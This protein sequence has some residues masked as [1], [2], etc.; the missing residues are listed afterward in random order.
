MVPDRL[1][2]QPS[3]NATLFLSSSGKAVQV[4][5]QLCRIRGKE[6]VR[7]PDRLWRNGI[8]CRKNRKGGS[9][10]FRYPCQIKLILRCRSVCYVKLEIRRGQTGNIICGFCTK[11]GVIF[12]ASRNGSARRFCSKQHT[13]D[14]MRRRLKKMLL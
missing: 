3:D 8:C 11:K 5:E 13:D 6:L 4:S 2:D 9:R 12:R 14:A 7:R 1:S 10:F